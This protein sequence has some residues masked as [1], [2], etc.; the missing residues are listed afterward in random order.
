MCLLQAVSASVGLCVGVV[1]GYWLEI[2]R[3]G[4]VI[5]SSTTAL[6]EVA[7]LQLI[8]GSDEGKY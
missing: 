6:Y 3:D 7:Y 8:D 4:S 1:R 5:S 2:M